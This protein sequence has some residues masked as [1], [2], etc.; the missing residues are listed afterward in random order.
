MP[1]PAFSTSESSVLQGAFEALNMYGAGSGRAALL[2]L[3]RAVAGAANDAVIGARLERELLAA[4]Q[5]NGS[6]VAREFICSKL[7]LIGSEASV[8]WLAPLLADPQ[9]NQAAREA[10]EVMPCPQ[11]AKALRNSLAN[12]DGPRTIGVIYSLGVRRDPRSVGVLEDLLKGQD[13]LVAAAAA[14]ALGA[15]G[16]SQ[17]AKVLLAFLAQTPAALGQ[18]TADAVLVCAERLL[19]SERRPEA[20]GLY[21]RLR[22]PGQPAH[23]QQAAALGLKACAGAL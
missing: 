23:V 13:E 19:A 1:P 7:A 5:R 10:L 2:P 12:L 9:L 22:V 20:Q 8:P 6:R 11:A 3:D 21:L 14:A 16:T 18:E 15:I 4:L 17:A